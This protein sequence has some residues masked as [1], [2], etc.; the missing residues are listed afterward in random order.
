MFTGIITATATVVKKNL[1]KNGMVLTVTK[2]SKWKVGI[3]AS[4]TVNGVC[5]TLKKKQGGLTFEYMPES[6]ERANIGSLEIGATVNLE[7]S[8]R[9]DDRL[10]GHIIQGHVDTI[11]SI[12]SIVREGNSYIFT[13]APRDKKQLQM[14]AEKGS[15]AIEGISLTVTRVTTKN[16]DFK[17][18]PYTWDH[19]NLSTKKAGDTVN[20]EIDVLAKYLT[21]FMRYAKRT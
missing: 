13:I 14:I 4:I 17:I 5:S 10:D 11:G 2:P 19:T 1:T 8:L 6:L 9:A 7:Q 15:I 16:F 18:I 21:Q 3:G 20:I 12:N